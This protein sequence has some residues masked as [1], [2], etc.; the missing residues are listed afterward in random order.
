MNRADAKRIAETVTNDQLNAMFER[1]K[2][3]ITDWSKASAVNPCI[4]K[5]K[6]WN[7]MRRVDPSA[8]G[9]GR[10]DML[11]IKNMVWEF[12]DFL[13]DGIKPSRKRASRQAI[14]V[15]HE[16]PVFEVAP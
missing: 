7:I 12:G 10:R 14:Q 2:V 9:R 16:D 3:G 15:H 4:S 11:I 8:L 5:G 1:A 6:S 13:E